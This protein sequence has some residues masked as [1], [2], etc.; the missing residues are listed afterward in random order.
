MDPKTIKKLLHEINNN[1][2]VVSGRVQMLLEEPTTCE[3]AKNDLKIINGQIE[4][5]K[6]SLEQLRATCQLT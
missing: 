5:I 3:N 2:F 6:K 1:L 4:K